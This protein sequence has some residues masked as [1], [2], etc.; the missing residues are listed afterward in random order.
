MHHKQHTIDVR[1]EIQE[2]KSRMGVSDGALS[3]HCEQ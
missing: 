3:I 1:K 2:A